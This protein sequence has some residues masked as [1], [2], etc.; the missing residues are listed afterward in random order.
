MPEQIVRGPLLIPRADGTV[1]YCADG[2]LA[3]DTRGVLQW[4]GD[5]REYDPGEHPWRHSDG[6]MLPPLIDIHIHVPQHP[7]RG[8]FTEGVPDDAPGGKLLAGLQ[9]NVFPAEAR[10]D[11]RDIAQRVA[12]DFLAD[13]L[14]HGV[15]GGAAYVT[16]S[17][18]AVETTLSILPDTWSA[19]LVLMNQNCPQ[20]LR[21]R[22]G[23]L[24]EDVARLAS[25]FGRRL[26]MADRFAVAV[27]SPLRRRGVALAA[28]L[29]LRT[30]THLNEQTQE[31][32]FVEKSLYPDASSY[33][34][35]YHQDGLL[36]H[37]CIIAH[38][39]HMNSDEW[40]ILRDTG[41]VIA[42][43][44]TSNTHLGSGRMQL[45]QV[46]TYGIPW[47]LAT[48]V[49]ASPTVSMLA[50]MGRF[51]QVQSGRSTHAT[52]AAA[53]YRATRA[54]AEMLGLETGRL[55]PGRPMSFIE[56]A[57][58][59]P[60]PTATSDDVIRSLIPADL[61]RPPAVVT[62]VTLAGRV[63]YERDRADA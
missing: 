47:A 42:H 37:Q 27:D 49:G 11:D 23:T 38:C 35:V 16:P 41:S 19:G 15:V 28:R 58:P 25:R 54:P 7:I 3:A 18:V 26:I 10:C 46:E 8:R 30:Q 48:D 60:A 43:C 9:R 55:E 5:W 29:G 40:R 39:I 20:N 56:V 63:I 12:S 13:T 1:S 36:D 52:P 34:G 24:E 45:E 17:P 6:V 44:P 50:E 51:L 53:L 31:K 62:R 59:P 57:V 32:S 61:N 4:A 33:A 2:V 21:T 22:E 14:A